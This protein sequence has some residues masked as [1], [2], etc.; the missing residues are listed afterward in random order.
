MSRGQIDTGKI[1]TMA[2]NTLIPDQGGARMEEQL[3]NM[4]EFFVIVP[5]LAIAM[6]LIAMVVAKRNPDRF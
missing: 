2:K 3:I 4:T 1:C 5:V 6:I